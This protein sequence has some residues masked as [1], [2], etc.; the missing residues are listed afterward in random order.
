[1]ETIWLLGLSRQVADAIQTLLFLLR[2]AHLEKSNWLFFKSLI[3]LETY[4][5]EVCA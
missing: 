1:M 4:C 2:I 3:K 5:V